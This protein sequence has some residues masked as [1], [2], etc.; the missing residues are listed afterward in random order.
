MLNKIKKEY[1][2]RKSVYKSTCIKAIIAIIAVLII[3]T[4]WPGNAYRDT[5]TINSNPNVAI[6][7]AEPTNYRNNISQIFIANYTHLQKVTLYV[8]EGTTDDKFTATL[9]DAK[10]KVLAKEVVAVPE[11]LPARVDVLMD[12]AVVPEDLYTIKITSKRYVYLGQSEWSLEAGTIATEAYN[13]EL[14]TGMNL[15]MD[16][17]YREPIE[18]ATKIMMI[19]ITLIFMVLL[20]A[21][22]NAIF[23]RSDKDKLITVERCVKY[24]CNPLIIALMIFCIGASVLGYVSIYTMDNIFAVV[25]TLLL[26]GVLFYAVNHDRTG[27]Q[28]VVTGEYIRSHFSDILQSVAIAGALWACC[29]YVSGLYTIHHL[30]AERKQMLWFAFIVITM[31]A[32]GDIFTL[33]NVIYFVAAGIAGAVYYRMNLADNMSQDD[34]FVLKAS[35]YVAILLG[36]ILIRTIKALIERKGKLPK[37]VPAYAALMILY[38]AMIIIFRNSRWWTVVLVVAF[39]LLYLNYAM[40]EKRDRFVTNLMRGAIFQFILATGYCWLYRPYCSFRSARYTHIFHTSTITA[41]YM[42]MV[43]CVAIVLVIAKVLKSCVK[44]DEEGKAQ[45]VKA[46]TLRDIWKELV[47]FGIALTYLFMTMARTAYAAAFVAICFALLFMFW[48]MG[49]GWFKLMLKSVGY[50]IISVIVMFPIVFEIQRTIPCLVSEPKTYDIENYEDAVMRGRRL[51]QPEYMTVG[52]VIEIFC[53]KILG[54]DD[55]TM[56]IYNV[57][58][59]YNVYQAT[60]GDLYDVGFNW[61]DVDIADDEWD[62]LPSKEQMQAYIDALNPRTALVRKTREKEAPNAEIIK[63]RVYDYYMDFFN[64]DVQKKAIMEMNGYATDE[65]FL[66]AI[67]E[68][69]DNYAMQAYNLHMARCINEALTENGFEPE[70]SEDLENVEFPV[71]ESETLEKLLSVDEDEATDEEALDTSKAV[72]TS[73]ESVSE[74]ILDSGMVVKTVEREKTSFAEEEELDTEI[75]NLAN[76]DDRKE[77]DYTNGRISIYKSYLEQ[78][79]MTGHDHMGAI[80]ENGEEATH[81]HDVYLQVAYDHGIPTAIVFTL[82]GIVSFALATVLYKKNRFTAP[83]KALPAVILLAFAVAGVVEWIFHLSHPMGFTVLM[84]FAPVLFDTKRQEKL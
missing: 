82:F 61:K 60:L 14:K 52:R 13:D 58:V 2:M 27:E 8:G 32:A 76:Y 55:G 77:N 78:L 62:N 48:G 71:M 81:A 79:N 83:N 23:K 36:F 19:V 37:V 50:L 59:D 1:I 29:E 43:A 80:L 31:F 12:V 38:F 10:G 9:T 25:A 51:S 64:G 3:I 26:G 56:D 75:F 4:I 34:I 11:K 63:K 54:I 66:A 39:T 17:E 53:D 33:Y 65:E 7:L 45:I 69:A 67:E 24:V 6:T 40:W 15:S 35:I 42:T 28:S 49:K 46:L 47:F 30:V 20:T 21:L 18:G 44:K 68:E 41:T 72:F 73:K 5:K 57:Y 74:R 70:Y 22:V 16:Y 84:C